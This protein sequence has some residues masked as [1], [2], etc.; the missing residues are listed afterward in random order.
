M[1][2]KL[3]PPI[4]RRLQWCALALVAFM[5]AAM[6]WQ[7]IRVQEALLDAN[8]AVNR[9]LES[10]ALIQAFKST[11]LDL[12]T[13]ERGYVI[14]GQPAYLLPYQQARADACQACWNLESG[15]F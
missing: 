1:I 8:A 13:G 5:L 11:L 6:V 12:E 2:K 4:L 3:T 15:G 14:T 10:I 7:G 9:H